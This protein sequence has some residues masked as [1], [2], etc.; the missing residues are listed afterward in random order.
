LYEFNSK[1]DSQL[2]LPSEEGGEKLFL[3]VNLSVDFQ[4]GKYSSLTV[5]AS[6]RETTF[7]D[8]FIV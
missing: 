8:F 7:S 2:Q 4:Q 1:L 5:G 6:K 3:G